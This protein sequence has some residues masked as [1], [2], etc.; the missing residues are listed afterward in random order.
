MWTEVEYVATG[1]REELN[2]CHDG[3][4]QKLIYHELL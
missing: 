4:N 3:I 2:L 1:S